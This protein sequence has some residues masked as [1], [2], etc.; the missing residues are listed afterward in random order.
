[1][2]NYTDNP[3]QREIGVILSYVYSALTAVIGL[4]YVPIL[5]STIGDSEYGLYQLIGSIMS[6]M[7]LLNGV[8]SGGITRYY[9]KYL[10]EGNDELMRGVLAAGRNIYRIVSLLAVLFGVVASIAFSIAYQ[11]VLTDFQMAESY[12]MLGAVTINLIV[13]MQNS[14]SISVIVANERFIFQKGLQLTL[15][16]LQP[17]IVVVLVHFFPY[18]V[19]VPLIQ[20]FLNIIAAILQRAYAKCKLLMKIE[21]CSKSSQLTQGLLV[22]AGGFLL[23]MIADQLFW[24]TNQLILGFYFGTATVAVYAVASQ[25]VTAYT[26]LGLAIPQVFLPKVTALLSSDLG[27]QDISDLFIKVGRLTLYPLLFVLTGFIAFGMPFIQLWAGEGFDEAYFISL[28]LMIAAT[29]DLSQ[30]LGLTILQALNKYHIRGFIYLALALINSVI[31]ALLAP[32][33]GSL[34]AAL[35]SAI[36]MLIG[37]GLVM[38]FYYA[39]YVGLDIKKFWSEALHVLIPLCVYGATV[40]MLISSIAISWCWQLLVLFIVC[41][42]IV[43]IFVAVLFSMNAYEINLIKKVF[44]KITKK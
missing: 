35:C 28:C 3:K 12:I 5:L 10:A 41:F 15:L 7:S 16:I 26:S 17:G 44:R 4:L 32:T 19:L 38:N 36:A 39:K 34:G 20:L 29:I 14:L 24:K 6:Y 2:A 9:C 25:I 27:M 43:F 42:S 11:P 30:N 1:M 37:N 31:V 22:F 18:A 13:T 8:F 40:A 23:V 21:S 33:F